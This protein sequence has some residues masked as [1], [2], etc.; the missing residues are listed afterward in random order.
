MFRM[1]QDITLEK[2]TFRCAN[3]G[4]EQAHYTDTIPSIYCRECNVVLDPNPL[5]MFYNQL[6]RMCYHFMS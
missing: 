4:V 3:C 5:N 2:L 6:Y 1:V